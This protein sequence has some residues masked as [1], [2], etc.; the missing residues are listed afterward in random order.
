MKSAKANMEASTIKPLLN[1]VSEGIIF[2]NKYKV[3]SHIN[4]VA[5]SMLGL[6]PGEALGDT[7]SR[8]INH[9]QVQDLI[10]N[11]IE[12]DQKVVDEKIENE[13]LTISIH[14]IKDKFGDLVRVV[15]ILKAV[16]PESAEEPKSTTK[17]S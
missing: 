1:N 3:V 9:E 10:E 15:I 7:I 8:K 11:T 13:D 12:F 17:E 5:E 14:P 16:Q 6:I 2:V 4:H